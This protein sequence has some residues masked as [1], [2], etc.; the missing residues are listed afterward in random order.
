MSPEQALGR[1][2][3]VDCRTDIYSLGAALFRSHCGIGIA[4]FQSTSK[5]L[6]SRQSP[7]SPTSGTPQ[8]GSWRTTWRDSWKASR[9]GPAR[10][11]S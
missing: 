8:R 3:L 1:A 9:Y 7:N 5:R 4:R 10:R 6:S 2:E 11:V